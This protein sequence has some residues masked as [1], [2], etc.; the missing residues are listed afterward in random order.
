MYPMYYK[1]MLI[2]CSSL[3]S[4]PACQ[5]V[6]CAH[7][8]V[9]EVISKIVSEEVAKGNQAQIN[10]KE[11]NGLLIRY[12]VRYYFKRVWCATGAGNPRGF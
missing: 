9:I 4:C 8:A 7:G 2:S 6:R 11:K 1:L 12:F 3:P 5:G 10:C